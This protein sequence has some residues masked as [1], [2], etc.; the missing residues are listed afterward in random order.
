MSHNRVVRRSMLL[1]AAVA[2]YGV[3]SPAHAQCRGGQGGMRSMR[4]GPPQAMLQALPLQQFQ[5]PLLGT[6]PN[7]A[8]LFGGQVPPNQNN[9]LQADRPQRRR[10]QPDAI[11]VARRPAP[12]A[13]DIPTEP[14][15]PE[16]IAATRVDMARMLAGDATEAQARGERDRAQRLRDRAHRRLTD[17]V[18]QFPGTKAAARAQDLLDGF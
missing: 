6:V 4:S 15:D 2:V 9:A 5:N 7:Q 16:K 11:L 18:E 3:G 10:P 12:I 8:F 13:D 1:L 14:P 17:V